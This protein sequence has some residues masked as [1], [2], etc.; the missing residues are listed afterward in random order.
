MTDSVNTM[1]LLDGVENRHQQLSRFSPEA[2][3]GCR[4]IVLNSCAPGLP[5]VWRN[6][7]VGTE[8]EIGGIGKGQA[9]GGEG[10]DRF[11]SRVL[12]RDIDEPV[13]GDAVL[14]Q[15]LLEGKEMLRICVDFAG[16]ETGL[17][18]VCGQ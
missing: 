3:E 16:G 17:E 18:A 12:E 14:Q 10:L 13:E 15:T 5:L 6:R 11:E 9:E 4:S 8:E 1:S 7:V 2:S